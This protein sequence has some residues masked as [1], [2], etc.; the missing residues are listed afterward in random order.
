MIPKPYYDHD[1]ITIYH[2]DNMDIMPHLGRF[3]L[4]GNRTPDPH[5]AIVWRSAESLGIRESGSMLTGC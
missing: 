3:D 1:G 2:G 5:N 4:L